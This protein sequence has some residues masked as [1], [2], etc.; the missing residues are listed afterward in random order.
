MRTAKVKNRAKVST[1]KPS[2]LCKKSS[3]DPFRSGNDPKPIQKRSSLSKAKEIVGS[4][5]LPKKKATHLDYFE[6]AI[7]QIHSPF[8]AETD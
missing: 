7:G 5:F 1:N 6:L 2:T 8:S 4:A 3:N